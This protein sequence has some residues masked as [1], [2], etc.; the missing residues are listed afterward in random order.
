VSEYLYASGRIMSRMDFH[1]P[2]ELLRGA[3][4]V[5]HRLNYHQDALGSTVMLTDGRGKV[6]LACNYDAFGNL[7]EGGPRRGGDEHGVDG[8]LYN[9]KRY[10]AAVGLYDYGFR[11]YNP[12]LGRWT[13]PDPIKAGLNWYVYVDNDPINFVDPRGLSP[14]DNNIGQI[15]APYN[16]WRIQNDL[17]AEITI[18]PYTIG[19]SGCK[20]IAAAQVVSA[21]AGTEVTPAMMAGYVDNEGN[22]SQAEILKAISDNAP[23]TQ[24][25]PDYWEKKLDANRLN[26]I[27][28]NSSGATYIIAKA[29]IGGGIGEH[30]VVV[31]DYEVNADGKIEY[32][33][34]GSSIN[35]YGTINNGGQD[36]T[37][38]SGS[39]NN[40]V[41]QATVVR[42]ET[43]FV[44]SQ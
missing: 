41:S 3:G 35:D 16:D 25:T 19:Q 12:Q 37:F 38:T 5:K 43:Y 42:I 18:G 40:S 23:G 33:V 11:D 20:V 27:K 34:S 39:N 14:S 44:P 21:I 22:L 1:E 2:G 7:Y 4:S 10:D 30:Y 9:A 15:P 31:T 17:W 8:Y 26:T 24:V 36:R 6:E 28:S 32:T 29:I 13:T